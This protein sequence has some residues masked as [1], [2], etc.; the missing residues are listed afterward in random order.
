MFILNSEE[1]IAGSRVGG[2]TLSPN[3]YLHVQV[4]VRLG[5]R[6]ETLGLQPCQEADDGA[7]RTGLGARENQR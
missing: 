2:Q 7:L 1:A 4:P 3:T 6:E 5:A